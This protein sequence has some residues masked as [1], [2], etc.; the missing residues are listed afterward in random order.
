M[1]SSPD[2]YVAQLLQGLSQS[3]RGAHGRERGREVGQT[4]TPREKLCEEHTQEDAIHRSEAVLQLAPHVLR[5][6]QLLV[7]PPHPISPFCLV[8]RTGT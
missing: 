5:G 3:E 7:N 4:S 8:L 6:K 1:W 2:A